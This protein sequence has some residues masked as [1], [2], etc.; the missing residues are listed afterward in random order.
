MP[1][2]SLVALLGSVAFVAPLAAGCGDESAC[3]MDLCLSGS[4][5]CCPGA[6]R[7]SWNTRTSACSCPA[8]PDGGADA[9][10]DADG[11]A[12]ARDDGRDESTREDVRWEAEACED[13]AAPDAP[14]DACSGHGTLRTWPCGVLVCEC[15]E[16]YTP[17]SAAG[18][19]CVP[20]AEVCVGGAVDFDWNDDGT[21]EAMLEPTAAECLVLEIVNR[22]RATH[23]PED[24]PECHFPLAYDPALAADA[25]RQSKRM[26]DRGTPFTDPDCPYLQVVAT[27]YPPEGVIDALL[28]DATYGTHCYDFPSTH[29]N[30]VMCEVTS[31][32]P[33]YWP[34]EGP[35][36]YWFALDTN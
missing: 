29:C 10:A 19:D 15:D 23:D 4:T 27:G 31:A 17:S 3:S 16:G 5:T 2:T 25:R 34:I 6:G 33:G 20:T 9:D 8:V 35:P 30:I 1:R 22:T 28:D 12:D 36:D 7:G 26:S 24:T 18:L 13:A 11:D 14:P 21:N 32:G